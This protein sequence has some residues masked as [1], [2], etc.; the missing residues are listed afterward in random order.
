MHIVMSKW[1]IVSLIFTTKWWANEQ[2][3]GGMRTFLFLHLPR[4]AEWMIRGAEK[5][6]P[7]RF[8][9]H[10]N[11]KIRVILIHH[12]FA[13]LL[14]H[15][16]TQPSCLWLVGTSCPNV[17]ASQKNMTSGPSMCLPSWKADSFSVWQ[18]VVK[19]RVS[20][21]EDFLPQYVI[22]SSSDVSY[23]VLRPSYLCWW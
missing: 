2:Y 18:H 20:N 12:L 3:G 9:Q 15:N 19:R 21:Q 14:T 7:L 17:F 8:K 6:H 5:H 10:P 23:L 11:W 22:H 13:H 16:L 1:A 4:A